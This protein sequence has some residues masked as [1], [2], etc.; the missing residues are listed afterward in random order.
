MPPK[1]RPDFT[2]DFVDREK[3]KLSE[4]EMIQKKAALQSKNREEA[5]LSLQ[6]RRKKLEQGI[7]DDDTRKV[8]ETALTSKKID[9][10]PTVRK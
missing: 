2:T 5:I 9:I 4:A 7:I 1:P 8:Y 3:Y 6:E 10:N